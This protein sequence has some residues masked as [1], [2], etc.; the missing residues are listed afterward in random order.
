VGYQKD[1]WDLKELL[2]GKD[3]PT[4]LN[5]AESITKEMELYKPVFKKNISEKK[6]G[7]IISLL[8]KLSIVSLRL[9]GYAELLFSENTKNQD[10]IAL[11]SKI[12]EISTKIGNRLVWFGL[13]F[14]DF[15]KKEIDRLIKSCPH[16]D[17][18][19]KQIVEHKKHK[20]KENEEKIINLK[21][22]NGIEV[23]GK[24]YDLITSS[25]E[26]DLDGK[27]VTQ[28][29]LKKEFKSPDSR[30]RE[31]AYKT[32]LT[33][34]S[35]NQNILGELYK[36]I[37]S[38]WYDEYVVM[39]KYPS[40]ISVRNKSQDISNK[41][42]SALINTC[43]RN[44]EV[45]HKFFR[46]KAKQLKKDKLHRTD[47]YAPINNSKEKVGYD[48]AITMVLDSF[49]NFS[50]VFYKEAKNVIDKR[51][52][53]SKITPGKRNGGFCDVAPPKEYPYI[54]IS[55]TEDYTSTSSLAHELGHAIQDI[56]SGRKQNIFNMH[57]VLPIAETSS[58]FSELLLIQYLKNR[59]NGI[60]KELLF[61]QIENAYATVGRQI[62]FVAF[63]IEAHELITKNPTIEEI[64]Q[65]YLSRLKKHFGGDVIIPDYF[66]HEWLYIRHIFDTP[67]YC[68]AYAFGNLLSLAIY[69]AYLEN[70]KIKD[71][72]IEFLSAGSSKSPKDLVKEL[73]F[74]IE[75]EKFW[76]KGFD[77]IGRMI[78]EIE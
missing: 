25:L 31:S 67:F 46:V 54:L 27:N 60:A 32:L 78:K 59:K 57:A 53:H 38:D 39:R 68:Y 64:N 34:Y 62:E 56:L 74:D 58:I 11:N 43:Q 44:Q 35:K 77:Q 71:K 45:F 6:F 42:I 36:A 3:I 55:F 17:Y 47:V 30:R 72:F 20:L 49:K 73:G 12:D 76:Q 2:G 70:P 13:R 29:E 4:L 19:L 21:D 5:Q 61:N 26:F 51:H 18:Y 15:P 52:I 69:S 41:A 40:P 14:V 66:K 24:I 9:E 23:I 37:A 50:E 8:E 16:I 65:L 48:E 28:E 10:A 1:S 22:K 75:D 7:E 33:T 63:E